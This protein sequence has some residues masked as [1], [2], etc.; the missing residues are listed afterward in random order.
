MRNPGKS[1]Q[2]CFGKQLLLLGLYGKNKVWE[3]SVSV[4]AQ[5]EQRGTENWNGLV[6]TAQKG[7]DEY[8]SFHRGRTFWTWRMSLTIRT[9]RRWGAQD[10]YRTWSCYKLEESRANGPN[11]GRQFC[12][13]VRMNSSLHSLSQPS[14][15][16]W[17]SRGNNETTV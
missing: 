10:N 4:D 17:H 3:D 13:P 8:Q 7:S 5:W 2:W 16:K 11:A 6:A 1:V 14:L 12:A 9:E 15:A